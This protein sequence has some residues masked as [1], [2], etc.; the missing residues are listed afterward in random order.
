MK[1][2][3]D[4]K[5]VASKR[6]VLDKAAGKIASACNRLQNGFA[7]GMNK[8][9]G[10]MNTERL[11]TAVVLFVV[12]FGG[13]SFYFIVK[14]LASPVTPKLAVE[15]VAVPKHFNKTGD[16]DTSRR[17][18]VDEETFQKIT[19]FKR[20]MDNLKTSK[21]TQYDSITAARPQLMDSIAMLEQ[22]YNLQKQNSE[23]E[24]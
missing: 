7:T 22:I 15:Q 8:S 14:A 19:A 17:S 20:Y 5:Q 2:F 13:V 16:D 24:K 23:Y 10:R 21:R 3:S 18:Y 4:E 9:V 1:F 12:V 11:K 6:P